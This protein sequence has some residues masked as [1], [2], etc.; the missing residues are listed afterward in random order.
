[1][2][3]TR[4]YQD[5]DETDTLWGWDPVKA[6]TS[7]S[8]TLHDTHWNVEPGKG[9]QKQIWKIHILIKTTTEDKSKYMLIHFLLSIS[10]SNKNK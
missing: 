2:T 3:K 6:K 1:M 9:F 10:K 4:V 8:P 7:Q 5:Q